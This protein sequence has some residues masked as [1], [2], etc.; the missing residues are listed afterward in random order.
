MPFKTWCRSNTWI[1][2]FS[3]PFIEERLYLWMQLLISFRDVLW[4]LVP[5]YRGAVVFGKRGV[6]MIP[7]FRF[8]SP[9]IEERLYF[10]QL[11]QA[12]KKR[13]FSSPFIEERLY[14]PRLGGQRC[15]SILVL[16]PF[17]RGAVVFIWRPKTLRKSR[18]FSSPFIEERLYLNKL[19]N[20]SLITNL[21]SSPFI[22]ERLYFWL[23]YDEIVSW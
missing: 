21:F 8:S 13:K 11:R 5:F 1:I 16:V 19:E 9:F 10:Y 4:V 23:R 7:K 18:K 22:E 2:W 6:D 3:S 20:T 14:F 17:Y 15:P 12:L